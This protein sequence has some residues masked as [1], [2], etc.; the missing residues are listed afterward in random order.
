MCIG[1]PHSSVTKPLRCRLQAWAHPG[2]P[3]DIT[4]LVWRSVM[5]SRPRR[6]RDPA[7]SGTFDDERSVTV[8]SR[9]SARQSR[10]REVA[11]RHYAVGAAQND[12]ARVRPDVSSLTLP[13][14]QHRRRLVLRDSQALACGPVVCS[15]GWQSHSLWICL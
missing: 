8:V 4:V 3:G 15:D 11:E 13:S 1:H 6:R 10:G 7:V 12:P 14:L 9:V 5:T 2:Q